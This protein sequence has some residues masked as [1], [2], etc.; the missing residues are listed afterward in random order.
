MSRH[1]RPVHNGPMSTI[2]D[3]FVAADDAAAAGVARG[4][5]GEELEPA[6]YGNFDVWSALAEWESVA[7]GCDLEELLASGGPAVVS[8]DDEPLVLVVPPALTAALAQA[9]PVAL[10]RFAEQW[11]ALRAEEGEEIEEELARDLLG[12]L[13]SLATK[14]A[15][16][17]GSLYCWIC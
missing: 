17:G 4:G 14:A 11:I 7:T 9:G 1:R 3:F 2:I 10:S 15:R 16:T 13:A 6:T 12:E 8:G 5:P